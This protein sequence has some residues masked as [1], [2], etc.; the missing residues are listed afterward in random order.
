MRTK[1]KI[2]RQQIKEDKFTNYMLLTRDWFL[3]NWQIVAILAA[4]VALIIA[5]TVYFFRMKS[6]KELDAATRLTKAVAEIRRQN[7]QVAILELK[8]ISDEFGGDIGGMALFNLGNAY[9]D[10]KNYDEAINSFKK[11]IDEYKL[12]KLTTASAYAGIAVSLE[13]KG[14]FPAAGDKFVEAIRY[15]PDSPSAPDYYLGAVRT[16][17]QA[18]DRTKADQMFK[19]L[20]EK[21]PGL[22]YSRTAARLIAQLKSQ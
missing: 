19:E 15:Y 3:D 18:G 10:S 16:Y 20:E 11:Y 22:E 8:T 12:D 5:G 14:D 6:S 2:T 21:F 13:C 4:V 9:Y 1:V 7:F 17:V